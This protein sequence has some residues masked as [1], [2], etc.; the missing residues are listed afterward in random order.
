MIYLTQLIYIKAGYAEA[1][2]EFEAAVIPI[3]ARY[4][5]Q[6]LLRIRPVR[7]EIIQAGIQSPYEVHM[8]S[9]MSEEDYEKFKLDEDRK[10][11]LHLKEKSIEKVVLIL[12]K[13]V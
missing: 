6:L 13:E 4:N 1:F 2:N 9:F 8:V 3:I 7:N 12:G 5:G 10:K 11:Y